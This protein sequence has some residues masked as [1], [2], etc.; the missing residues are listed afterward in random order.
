[1]VLL[2]TLHQIP[3]TQCET[4]KPYCLFQSVSPELA[5]RTSAAAGLIVLFHDFDKQDAHFRE[6]VFWASPPTFIVKLLC[7]LKDLRVADEFNVLERM[8]INDLISKG[9]MRK[10]T[11]GDKVYYYGLNENVAARLLKQL[12]EIKKNE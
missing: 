5:F 10:M 6:W 8:I 9:L 3:D 1:M 2:T 7:C 11:S 4:P 12:L